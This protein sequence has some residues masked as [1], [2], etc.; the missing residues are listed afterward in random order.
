M[1]MNKRSG[2]RGRI[3]MTS[4]FVLL[5]HLLFSFVWLRA[6][7]NEKLHQKIWF[8][9]LVQGYNLFLTILFNY[10]LPQCRL[11]EK[12]KFYGH[13]PDKNDDKKEGTVKERSLYPTWSMWKYF[14]ANNALLMGCFW[15]AFPSLPTLSP[16]PFFGSA[17]WPNVCKHLLRVCTEIFLCYVTFEALEF[18][19]HF[20]LHSPTLFKTIHCVHHKTMAYPSITGFY[21]HPLDA[22][23]EL[24]FNTFIPLLLFVHHQESMLTFLLLGIFYIHTGH[25]GYEVP[26][27]FS[28]RHHF[29]HHYF[30]N[31]NYAGGFFDAWLGVYKDPIVYLSQS[32]VLTR[33]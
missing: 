2:E 14:L 10:I 7:I 28:G 22:L 27:W 17:C 4:V 25:S 13:R 32:L 21:M 6:G 11:M 9:L 12:Y 33:T 1:N 5:L 16:L 19:V 3:K 30:L 20:A 29:L 26:G 15:F 8:T 23:L 24:V 18:I 31:A